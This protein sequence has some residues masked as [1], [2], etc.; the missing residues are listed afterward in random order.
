MNINEPNSIPISQRFNPPRENAPK[1]SSS[2]VRE[3][4]DK[5]RANKVSKTNEITNADKAQAMVISP[6]QNLNSKIEKRVT[7]Q[8]IDSEKKS[9]HK[10]KRNASIIDKEK[11][12]KDSINPIKNLDSGNVFNRLISDAKYKHHSEK[13]TKY[14]G[15]NQKTH[16]DSIKRKNSQPVEDRL[17]AYQKMQK[18]KLLQEQF[19]KRNKE[20]DNVF[21]S[22]K[23]ISYKKQKNNLTVKSIHKSEV[24]YE[25][26]ID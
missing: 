19:K 4:I 3:M 2:D 17:L 13:C 22:D 21:R 23:P 9:S 16:A 1:N 12:V 18:N 14:M 15:P 25:L 8:R 20:M 11:P 7:P 26:Q 24:I 5:R 10:E 6:R